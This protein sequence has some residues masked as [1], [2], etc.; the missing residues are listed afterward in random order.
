[1]DECDEPDCLRFCPITK[2]ENEATCRL[3]AEKKTR[4]EGQGLSLQPECGM[5][6]EFD[7]N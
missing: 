6:P 1:M 4:L 7:S 5:W 2:K 3:K